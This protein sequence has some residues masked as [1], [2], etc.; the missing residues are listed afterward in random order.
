MSKQL[1]VIR[2]AK[3]SWG[4]PELHDFDRPLNKRGQRDAPMMAKRLAARQNRP[5]VVISS[6]AVRALTTARII[7]AG[8]GISENEIVQ[9]KALYGA[10]ADTMMKTVRRFD[11]EF[12]DAMLIA[13]NPGITDLYTLLSGEQIDNIPT[14]GMFRVEFDVGSWSA[15]T[16]GGLV[17]YD[18]PKNPQS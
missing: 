8:F 15:I 9:D 10:S 2:H 18:Y 16:R 11:D 13:H 14:C 1:T 5:G 6:P 17:F 7:A 3:S 12:E 4:N